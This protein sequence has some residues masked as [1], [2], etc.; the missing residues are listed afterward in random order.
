MP[1]PAVAAFYVAAA[2]TARQASV[3]FRTG[4]AA[5]LIFAAAAGFV[6][7]VRR[8]REVKG[9]GFRSFFQ[10]YVG[11]KFL[12]PTV[13]GVGAKAGFKVQRLSPG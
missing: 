12:L 10:T 6:W 8:N 9:A 5:A 2:G 13:V 1:T 7:C 4:T 3:R 11:L